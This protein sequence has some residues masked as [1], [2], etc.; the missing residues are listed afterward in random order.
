[1]NKAKLKVIIL[2]FD[3]IFSQFKLKSLNF[4]QTSPVYFYRYI[5]YSSIV[6][7]FCTN[8]TTK[9]TENF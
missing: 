2:P 5:L 3:N 9:L 1:M 7:I 4:L 6:L 8:S